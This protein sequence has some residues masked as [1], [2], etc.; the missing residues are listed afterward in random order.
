MTIAERATK[1]KK[2]TKPTSK[3]EE[4]VSEQKV[5]ALTKAKAAASK[6]EKLKLSEAPKGDSIVVDGHRFVFG[7]IESKVVLVTAADATALLARNVRNRT[8]GSS[9]LTKLITDLENGDYVFNGDSIV[10]ATNGCVIDGQHRLTAVIQTGISIM[11]T[12]VTGV[13]PDAQSD[14]DNGKSRTLADHLEI[15]G[16]TNPNMLGG[17]LT[18]IQAYEKGARGTTSALGITNSTGL[19]FL[20]EHPEIRQISSEA[21]TLAKKIPSLTGKQIATAIWAFD[22]IDTDDRR[23][24]FY[25]L[26]TGAGLSEDHPVLALRAKLLKEVTSNAK[27]SNVHKMALL[28][29]AWNMYREGIMGKLSFRPGGANPEPFPEA[30]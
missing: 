10:I 30:R 28:F 8:I 5:S 2:T 11:V 19:A 17:T 24:F 18:G 4:S 6:A 9:N 1:A 7:E 27:L 21:A 16:E 25:K 22:N 23:D 15:L 26:S 3:P 20:R 12:I 29:K 14:I 13:H